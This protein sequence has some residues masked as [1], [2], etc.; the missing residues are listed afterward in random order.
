MSEREITGRHVFMVTAG[1]F[2]VIIAVNVTMAIKAVGSFPGLEV[3]NSYVAS[4]SF[5]RRR[6]A[7]EALGWE[8]AARYEDGRFRVVFEADG[9][10]VRPAE[11]A[12]LI[13][14]KTSNAE[15]VAPELSWAE[16][17]LEASVELA[18]GLW[19]VRIAAIAG[20][21]TGYE[22]RLDLMVAG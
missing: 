4:Q 15:D 19:T 10:K 14:R 13:G 18:P 6:A 9:Q 7:Q 22:K 2:G 20:D 5:D 16:G 11:V 8:V 17:G 12:V 3:K 21:G 1:A